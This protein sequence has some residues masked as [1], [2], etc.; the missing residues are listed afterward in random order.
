MFFYKQRYLHVDTS[1]HVLRVPCI[2]RRSVNPDVYKM[3]PDCPT[4]CEAIYGILSNRTDSPIGEWSAVMFEYCGGSSFSS[5]RE[6]PVDVNGGQIW[7]RE[8]RNIDAVLAHLDALGGLLT[9]ATDVVL[10]GDSAGGLGAYFHADTIADAV[11]VNSPNAKVVSV[12]GAGFF[13]DTPRLRGMFQNALTFW[14]ASL[15]PGC[16]A[17]KA[18]ADKWQCFFAQYV[19]P[20]SVLC[21]GECVLRPRPQQTLDPH[22]RFCVCST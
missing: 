14:N 5:D 18:D 9:N 13:L 7:L 10:T 2:P 22:T 17:A 21:R 6:D 4:C 11:H 16:L 1:K 20:V 8:R 3:C 19:Y 15:H 12:P